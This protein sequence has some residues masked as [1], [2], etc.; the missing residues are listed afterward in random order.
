VLQ[1]MR[2]AAKWIWWFVVIFFV[3]GFLLLDTSGLLG[4]DQLGPSTT[5]ATVNGVE[6][7]YLTWLNLSSTMAQQQEQA[8]GRGLSLD[9]RR[10]IE[11][12]AFEQLVE[13][14]LLQQE[15]KRRGISVSDEEVLQAAQSSPPA[16]LMADPS[17]QTDGQ[18]DIEKYR[19]FLNSPQAR[20]GGLLLQLENYYRAEIPRAKLYD[21][22][23]STVWVSDDKLWTVYR[24]AHDSAWVSFVAFSPG[25]VPDSAVQVSEAD[26]RRFYDADRERFR[27]QGR[28]VLSLLTIPR[29]I[30]AADTAATRTR[31]LEL[32]Q[33]I[34]DGARFEDVASAES[35]DS[36]SA[37]NGGSLGMAARDRF[38][39]EFANAAFR[40][41]VGE[42]SQPVLTPD[43]YH[44]IRVD[45]KKGDSISVRHILRRIQQSDSSATVTDR[46]ADQLA[47]IAASATEPQRF[48]S[49]ART[50]GLQPQTVQAFEGQPVFTA[51]GI[52]PGA[53]AWAFSGSRTGESSELF[54]SEQGYFLARLDTLVP[55]GIAPYDEV[56]ADIRALLVLRKK[57]EALLPDARAFAQEAAATSLEEAA[58][59]RD[60]TV[61]KTNAFAR[62][63]FVPGMGRLNAAVG[64]AFALPIG[65][66]SEPIVTD[67]GV[68]VMR[69]ERRQE[70]S[71]EEWE[72]QKE[73]QRQQ[74]LN[75][76]RQNRLRNF[77]DGL[78]E[79][80][81]VEDRRQQIS[82][83]ARQQAQ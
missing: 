4:R 56:K 73:V 55:S 15:Y 54:D 77:L 11:N 41:R 47:R 62:P 44:L 24:D 72:K 31:V 71:R 50:L 42:L 64:A 16:G 65:Q 69:A 60:I 52:A 2:S 35:A 80:A 48:D 3:G 22:I 19:R 83:A 25:T 33:Q 26:V 20:Q 68:F 14:I 78:R 76:L 61:N 27:R 7:P 1:Q 70:A 12:Q 40:L 23:M 74:T 39:P 8:T 45:A 58:R 43:G 18:F 29:T 79:R 37:A 34:V 53:S 10:E 30:T 63:T 66:I 21:Q 28:A 6:I 32:R 67:D 75:A 46:A 81:D 5:V 49:A 36:T 82:A 17:L 13:Q 57:S 9:E 51:S 59:K 38:T